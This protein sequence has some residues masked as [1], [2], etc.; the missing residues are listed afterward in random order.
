[1]WPSIEARFPWYIKLFG[2]RQVARSLHFLSMIAFT[3]FIIFHTAL[4]LIVHFQDNIRNIVLGNTQ[5]DLGLAIM[6]AVI[7]LIVVV[8]IYV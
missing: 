3:L 2:G 6:I 8:L 4:V 1:M 7:A 5:G